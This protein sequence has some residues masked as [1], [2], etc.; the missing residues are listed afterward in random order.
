MER[1]QGGNMSSNLTTL[2]DPL[3]TDWGRLVP[4]TIGMERDL[5]SNQALPASI[6]K[7]ASKQTFYTIRFLVDRD[8]VLDAYR[9]YAYFRWVDNWLDE[10][11]AAR[12]ERMA[13]VERQQA[14]MNRCYQGERVSDLMSEER[15]LVD[16]IRSDQEPGSGLQTYIRHMMAVMA[17]DAARRGRLISQQELDTYS[18]N[19]ASAVTEAL[20]YFIGHGQFAPHGETRYCAVTG[21]HITHMLRDTFED[22]AA[23]YFNIPREFLEANH[24]DVQ[25]IDSEAYR[26]WVRGRVH[27]ARACF[28]VGKRD[29]A[30]VE[31]RRCRIAGYAYMARFQG[32][33]DLIAREGYQLRPEYPERRSLSGGLRIGAAL[34]SML[35]IGRV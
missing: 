7:A 8:R 27:L 22:I 29:L 15:M 14:I 31:N 26:Q 18:W 33:L 6:T 25:D 13:F 9:T 1:P 32:V 3:K 4:D 2:S 21:A 11:L 12:A 5:L 35:M 19:L 16:L 34:L 23:G 17:F 28:A 20:H 24:I 10:Q 30:Q